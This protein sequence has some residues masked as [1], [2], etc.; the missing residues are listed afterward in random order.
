M[1]NTTCCHIGYDVRD[2]TG[3]KLNAGMF[4]FDQSE[5]TL[6]DNTPE[7]CTYKKC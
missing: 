7:I 5:A 4:S 6:N 3:T 2:E 1:S